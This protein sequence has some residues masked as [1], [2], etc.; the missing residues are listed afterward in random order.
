MAEKIEQN[1]FDEVGVNPFNAPVPGESL[2]SSPDTPTA[3]ERPPQY[4][5]QEE[6]M[7][8]VYMEL[9][10]AESLRKLVDIIDEGVALDEIAQVILYKGYRSGKFNP[11]MV[12]LLAEPTIYLLI[13]IADYA[14]ID[15]YV[16][17]EGEEEDD[18]DTQIPGDDVTP[19][20]MD[21]DDEVVEERTEPTEEVLGESL[22]AKVKKELPGK[23][24]AAVEVK[25]E[26]KE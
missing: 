17:Y 18:P 14:D 5:D 26:V 12:L 23:V 7:R 4:T 21:E 8:A 15:D 22:L 10:E 20:N 1:Q 16:L 9:T 24:E 25:E 13:A 6:A 11:D 3:W 2:T 19:I